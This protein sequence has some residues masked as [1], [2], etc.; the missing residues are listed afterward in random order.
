MQESR[1][2]SFTAETTAPPVANLLLKGQSL[3]QI[4]YSV[5]KA[6]RPAFNQPVATLQVRPIPTEILFT[7]TINKHILLN[8][9]SKSKF[10]K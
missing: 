3:W 1:H 10:T 4:W 2:R 6:T 8:W 9:I 5:N 7:K